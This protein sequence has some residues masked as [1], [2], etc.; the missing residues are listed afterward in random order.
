M[1]CSKNHSYKSP[2]KRHRL[3]F[4]QWTADKLASGAGSWSFIFGFFVFL[5]IWI[6]INFTTLWMVFYLKEPFDPYPFILLN[7][8]LS[9]LAA[10]QAPVILMAQNRAAQR[11]RVQVKK[12]YYVDRMAEKEIK[13]VQVQLLEIKE[14]LSKQ[15]LKQETKKIES[16]IK[17]IQIE[18]ENMGK[19]LQIK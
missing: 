17:S 15:S 5:G 3:S 2:W 16:E 11:D 18:L 8:F 13:M 19:T 9:C 6:V 14:L 1:D 12:D 7:L 10:I 4:G